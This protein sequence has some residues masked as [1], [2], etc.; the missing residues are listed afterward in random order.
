MKLKVIGVGD[1]V[2]DK[3]MHTKT[4]YPGGNAFNFS[5]YAQSLGA[6][7]S[8]MGVFGTDEAA[9]HVQSVA[10]KLGIEMSHC[11]VEE[12][13]NGAA[14]ISLVNGDRVFLGS[15]KGGVARLHPLEFDEED[16]TYLKGFDLICTSINSH[17][18]PQL[19]KLKEL[20][21]YVAYDFSIIETDEIFDAVC[22][23][24]DF[25]VTSCSSAPMEAIQEKCR[26]IH[27]R[28]CPYVIASRG[29]LG[30][31]FSHEGQITEHP[32]FTVEALD[33]LG[34]G[35]S[36]LTAFLLSFVGWLKEQ[37]EHDAPMP[38]SPEERTAAILSAMEAGSRFAAKTC[39]VHGAFGHGKTFEEKEPEN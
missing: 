28:G 14:R 29:S 1:N 11:R 33:T 9:A 32:A 7:A 26:R 15:N 30:S 37:K 19:P 22:P 35:D 20:P 2:V 16:L 4:M 23:Y 21:P 34:A 27:S 10:Q 24:I 12:G 18:N 39:M 31:A 17:I 38:P 8:Y 5:A 6:E 13:E 3:Y 25:A 36:F